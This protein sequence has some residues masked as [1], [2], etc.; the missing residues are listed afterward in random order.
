MKRF[1]KSGLVLL[2]LGLLLHSPAARAQGGYGYGPGIPAWAPAVGP[3]V[4][5]YYI[6]EIDGYYDLYSRSYLFFDPYYNSWVSAP[7]LPQRYASYD[8]RFFHPVVIQYVGRQ[9]WGYLRDHRAYCDRWGVRPGRYYGSRW[10]GRGYV[11]N[12]YGGY[13]NGY[14]GNGYYNNGYHAGRPQYS[15]QN[16]AGYYSRRNDDYRN[17]Y[18]D[19][20]GRNTR[21]DDRNQQDNRGS[22]GQPQQPAQPAPSNGRG[23]RGRVF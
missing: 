10:P 14:P 5:Y 15:Q 11:A 21:S 7:V 20:D 4:Q 16:P 22:Y 2:G 13:R 19:R 23:S 12:P 18:N 17:G 6:P 9:P 8:P 1:L 3:E